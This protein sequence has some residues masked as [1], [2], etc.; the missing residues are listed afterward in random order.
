M[1]RFFWGSDRSM[2][3]N[4]RILSFKTNLNRFCASFASA[5]SVRDI[6]HSGGLSYRMSRRLIVRRTDDFA[7]SALIVRHDTSIDGHNH[8]FEHH[9][10]GSIMH[11]YPIETVE[12]L[13]GDRRRIHLEGNHG[14]VIDDEITRSSITLTSPSR[15]PT[16]SEL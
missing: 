13:D 3:P 2:V 11:P 6:P 7:G 10:Q 8:F 9:D 16:S 5:K 12:A 1:H 14:L 4:F 15:V